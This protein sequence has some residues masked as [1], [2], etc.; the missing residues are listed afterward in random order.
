MNILTWILVISF[1][2]GYGDQGV[3]AIPFASKEACVAAG[4]AISQQPKMGYDEFLCV[5][6]RTGQA[7]KK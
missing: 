4:I 5:D 1:H 2:I 6:Q 3:T 7:V